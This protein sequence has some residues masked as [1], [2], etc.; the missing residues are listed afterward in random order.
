MLKTV[1]F[2]TLA[3][4]GEVLGAGFKTH[5]RISADQNRE[6]QRYWPCGCRATYHDERERTAAWL[7]CPEHV[8]EELVD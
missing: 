5:M 7:P 2:R 8:I 4:L 3:D 1:V 6:Y